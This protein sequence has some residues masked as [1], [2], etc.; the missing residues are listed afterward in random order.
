[1]SKIRPKIG[2]FS[3]II[4][5]TGLT[6]CSN[7]KKEEKVS[8][9]KVTTET[10]KRS[11]DEIG[12]LYVGQVEEQSAT[13]VSFTSMGTLN[14]VFVSEGQW[15][16]RGQLIATIDPTSAQS[17]L[18]SAKAQLNQALDALERMKMLHDQGS[19]TDIKWMEI[20]SQV[21]QAK[22]QYRL[23]EKQVSDCR[24]TAPVSGVIGSDVKQAG[25][26]VVP[27]QPVARI[28]N[29]DRVKVRVSV[30]EQELAGI[31]RG[32]HAT[33]SVTALGNQVFHSNQIIKGVEGDLMTHTYTIYALVSN[34]G[35][36]L[37]PGMV[38]NVS[39]PT[40]N[41]DNKITLPVRS[42]GQSPG[43]QHFVWTV[44]NGKA[45]QQHVS[46]GE[47]RGNRLVITDGLKEGD[48]VITE[49]YQK[50]GEGS[51]VEG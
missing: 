5:L 42:V 4:V 18:A 14:R 39:F 48:V 13:A 28:L 45:H 26:S 3:L 2:L 50:V 40:S 37:L 34:P 23:M 21:A 17:A 24:L 47:V 20:Q 35:H 31:H 10:A 7:S 36:Q 16:K 9:F 44:V 25:E 51:P 41:A 12:P 46:V 8:S 29:I 27:A 33:I 19:L 32:S 1:M 22:A 30:P 11:M 43:G 15:V 49:G 6:S 38:T